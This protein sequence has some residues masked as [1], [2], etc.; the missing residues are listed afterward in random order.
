MFVNVNRSK[1]SLTLNLK[2]PDGVGCSSASFAS[3]D[4]VG[5]ELP[6]RRCRAPRDRIRRP[7]RGEPAARL[8]LDE[9][10]R[11]T[12][13]G[14]LGQRVYD[15]LIQALTGLT[16]VQAGSDAG[17]P[18]LI[19]TILPD[20]LSA[21]VG[22]PR[23]IS[24]GAALPRAHR[25]GPAHPSVDARQRPVVPVGLG[26]GR[27]HFRRQAGAES[28]R[29][30]SFIDLIYETSDGYITVATNSNGEWQSM[31]RALG[32]AE[33]I[34]DERFTTAVGRIGEHQRAARAHPGRAHRQA[35]LATG[36]SLLDEYDVPARPRSSSVRGHRAPA[37][38]GRRDRL[39]ETDH[40]VAGTAAPSPCPRPVPRHRPGR[41]ARSAAASAS[42]TRRS[43]PSMVSVMRKSPRSPRPSTRSSGTSEH[44][45]TDAAETIP[46]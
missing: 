41:A 43:L 39:L 5:A 17:A 12:R 26:H 29:A 14:L 15:S 3:A 37:G 23:P 44:E 34:E 46:A 11:R 8:P 42:T 25:R 4:V 7:R 22:S 20:K 6:A 35:Q 32:H 16:T 40:P 1:R 33:W 19:R 13:P 24:A 18:R 21:V 36:S 27:L 30:A 28:S 2:A 31:C 9:R 10:L 38:A 45:N